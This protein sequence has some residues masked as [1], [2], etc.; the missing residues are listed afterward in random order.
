MI[1]QILA[2]WPALVLFLSGWVARDMLCRYRESKQKR[3]HYRG[4][5]VPVPS[6][7]RRSSRKV[8][9]DSR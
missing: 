2:L 5:H 1:A 6:A 7:S 9:P 4:G 3:R 8:G